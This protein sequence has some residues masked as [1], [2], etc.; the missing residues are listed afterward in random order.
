[1]EERSQ[2]QLVADRIALIDV[3]LK[4]AKGVD[5]VHALHYMKDT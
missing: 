2:L 3:M 4:Y 1:M 5:N